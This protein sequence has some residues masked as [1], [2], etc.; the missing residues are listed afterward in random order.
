MKSFKM[1][2]VVSLLSLATLA[3]C[4]SPQ[5]KMD[6]VA[7]GQELQKIEGDLQEST[8]KIT[9]IRGE[10]FQESDNSAM[11]RGDAERFATKTKN[12]AL[13]TRTFYDSANEF[14]EETEQS[15]DQVT[16]LISYSY[17]FSQKKTTTFALD[18]SVNQIRMTDMTDSK[19]EYDQYAERVYENIDIGGA[20][21]DADLKTTY[22]E[23]KRTNVMNSLSLDQIGTQVFKTGDSFTYVNE[24]NQQNGD[25]FQKNYMTAKV[26]MLNGLYSLTSYEIGK[27][28]YLTKRGVDVIEP[29]LMEKTVQ[30]GT[31]DYASVDASNV[32]KA[33]YSDY[34]KYEG[35]QPTVGVFYL[36]DG[37]SVAGSN[38]WHALQNSGSSPLLTMQFDT[39]YS[40]FNG[41]NKN[42]FAATRDKINYALFNT[43]FS[44]IPSSDRAYVTS[45][46]FA[47]NASDG[48]KTIP[49][50]TI[51]KEGDV[52]GEASFITT[53][54][55][56][57]SNVFAYPITQA[58]V[59]EYIN[60]SGG[61]DGLFEMEV[62]YPSL[63]ASQGT[64]HISL[65]L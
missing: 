12:F 50:T 17:N 59:Q 58:K 26:E 53:V 14:V 9:V 31:F 57:T 11:F 56:T 6:R 34:L 38:G 25:N 18:P 19:Y 64:V 52:T 42:R 23:R 39:N 40:G 60:A 30:K 43:L 51:T 55:G 20:L 10:V 5:M 8:K 3:G 62:L 28:V 1:W 29:V 13:V 65:G 32:E 61:S 35:L 22:E 36:V 4:S 27:E 7:T 54:D 37:S 15:T 33:E 41:T 49:L 2:G 16:P 63:D 44:Q 47:F 24:Q 48:T 45:I 46:G 21:T